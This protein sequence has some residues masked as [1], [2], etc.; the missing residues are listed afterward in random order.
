VRVVT[1][2]IAIFVYPARSCAPDK[3]E[4]IATLPM[5]QQLIVTDTNSCNIMKIKLKRCYDV[6]FNV[7]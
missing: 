3:D 7:Y 5:S 2:N 6:V 4:Q 1:V